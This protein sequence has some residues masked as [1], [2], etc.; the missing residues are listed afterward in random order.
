MQERL[1]TPVV[2]TDDPRVGSNPSSCNILMEKMMVS[3]YLLVGVE[4]RDYS[5]YL[6]GGLKRL[7]LGF[8]VPKGYKLVH[9]VAGVS[10]YDSNG[11]LKP[12]F[13]ALSRVK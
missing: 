7:A 1:K 6:S 13:W 2:E 3:D 12:K 4:S 9:E 8:D 10:V 5:S 11:R